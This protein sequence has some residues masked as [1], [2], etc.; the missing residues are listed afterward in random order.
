MRSIF[1]ESLPTLGSFHR[2]EQ[3]RLLSL[4]ISLLYGSGHRSRWCSIFGPADA[5]SSYFARIGRVD[6][7]LAKPARIT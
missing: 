4:P 3:R 5:P 7:T 2:R 1:C 6:H